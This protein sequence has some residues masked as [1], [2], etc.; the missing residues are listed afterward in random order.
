MT[1][2]TDLRVVKTRGVIRNALFEL[3]SEKP[4]PKI[5]ISEIC[6]RAAVNRKTFYRHYRCTGDVITELENEIL[7]EF[8]EILR[9]KNKS[10]LDAGA[11]IRDISAVIDS[12]REFFMR[13]TKQNPDL[14]SKGK[15]K[16]VLCR[17]I[18]VAL[19]NI[20]AIEDEPTLNAAAEFTVSGVLSLYS[21]WF[22][23]GCGNDL[24]FLTEVSVK[25]ATKGLA[26][27]VSEE[28]LNEMSL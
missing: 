5:T 18:A 26:A 2:R 19:K 3:M 24:P 25:M 27:F 1:P 28:K 16:A 11:V 9:S 22:D 8:S 14:F 4:L 10:I 6:A 21:A 13:L 23:G 20:G 17:M 15:I 12:R 7:D